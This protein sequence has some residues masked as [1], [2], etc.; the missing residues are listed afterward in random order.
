MNQLLPYVAYILE[1]NITN[2]QNN[3]GK[4]ENNN[5]SLSYHQQQLHSKHPPMLQSNFRHS[6]LL[7]ML[8]ACVFE[9]KFSILCGTSKI[10]AWTMWEI[11]VCSNQCSMKMINFLV[12]VDL[13]SW[14]TLRKIISNGSQIDVLVS[15][16]RT[17]LARHMI[18]SRHFGS[19]GTSLGV[20]SQV[21][22]H[23]FQ[24]ES[25]NKLMCRGM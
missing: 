1:R 12:L 14:T 24:I 8:F 25:L 23:W 5:Q 22:F 4:N 15:N 6:V 13:L 7:W 21:T 10:C 19:V 20:Q 11:L 17:A 16:F 9:M 2:K 3:N 18:V